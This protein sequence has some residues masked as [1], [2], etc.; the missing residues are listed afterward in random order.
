METIWQDCRY[1][2]R[3]LWKNPGF[4]AISVLVLALGIGANTSVFTLMNTLLLRPIVA[5]APE[6][7]VALYSRNTVRPGTFR[8][9]SFPNFEDILES[10]QTFTNVFAHET[11][12]VGLREGD[13]T[14]RVFAEIVSHSYFDT[15]GVTPHQGRFFTA[16][17]SRPDAGIPVAVVSYEY[18]RRRGQDPAMVGST[19]TVGGREL[20]VV[21]ITPRFFTGRIALLSPPVYLPV[22]IRAAASGF[23]PSM[24]SLAERSNGALMAVGRLRPGVELEEANRQLEALGARMA[25]ANPE[26][27]GEYSL[28][29]GPLSR[30]SISTEPSDD[31]GL[32]SVAALM[33]G[34]TGVVLLIA[35]INLANMLLA[36]GATRQREFA[37]RAAIGGDRSR[38]LRQ[39]L[40]EGLLLATLGGAAGMVVA[41]WSNT[42]LGAS[43]SEALSL[44]GLVAEIVVHSAPDGRVLLATAGFCLL[45]TLAFGLGPAW[46][47]SRPDVMDALRHDSADTGGAA[48]GRL[49]SRRNLLVV[50]QIALSLVLLVSA[51][52][53]VRGA[54][55]AANV[56]PGFELEGGLAVEIDASLIGYDEESSKDMY[57]QAQE[58]VRALP[59]VAAASVANNIPFGTTSSGR[60]VRRAEDLP[61]VNA[62]GVEE[63]ETVSSRYNV[64]GTD[65]FAALGVPILRGRDFTQAEAE[66]DGGPAVAIID[67]HLA[68]ELWPGQ[69]PVGR[70]IGLG[71]T[72]DADG[73]DEIEIVGLV[74]TIRDD[75]FPQEL[76]PHLYAPFG[77][78]FRT[79]VHLHVRM[80]GVVDD[81]QL[82]DALRDVRAEII[83]VDPRFPV[84]SMNTLQ[85]YIQSSPSLWIVRV[86]AAIFGAF[87]AL[88]LFL[89]VIGVYGVKAYAVAQRTREI[90]IRKALGATQG[91]TL[92]LVLREGMAVAVAGLGVGLILAFGVASLLSSL[93]YEV[94]ATD[95][96]TFAFAVSVLAGAA[97]MATYIPARRAA[98]VAPV[99][100]LRAE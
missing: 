48:A 28:M 90:G 49:L 60:R 54:M 26:I 74:P 13:A 12:N 14:T 39:L 46:R 95:P 20:E 40:T 64:I 58:R 82:S 16:E 84:V 32:G 36:R 75:L 66:T 91:G 50:A 97:F 1:A 56:D 71:S 100:A 86:G 85:G 93:L 65:Y 17:E 94:S 77:Q 57:R 29:A 76:G 34:M 96:V 83:A 88:A 5:E 19:I 31:D 73:G 55:A 25:E 62:A 43:L 11:T 8:G 37:V 44:N 7:L 98:R 21:G 47:Q 70:F 38:I 89:A 6:E 52:L 59:G 61:Q 81:T 18:W 2:A 80:A 23:G 51:G 10:N 72:R 87:G 78:N 67:E 41:Y 9:M 42:L 63:I 15:L 92:R 30:M 79:T 33:L 22:G 4:T 53:F 99:T 24:V 35:C 27:N 3:M 68:E 69:D 45:G